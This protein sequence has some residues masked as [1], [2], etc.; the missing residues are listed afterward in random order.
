MTGRIEPMDTQSF[1]ADAADEQHFAHTLPFKIAL[2]SDYLDGDEHDP[3]RE[4]IMEV[5]MF[6]LQR[7]LA[8]C[9]TAEVSFQSAMHHD[10]IKKLEELYYDLA[11][12]NRESAYKMNMEV[13][14]NVLKIVSAGFEHDSKAARAISSIAG[15]G[16]TGNQMLQQFD[17]GAKKILE[18]EIEILRQMLQD[19]G[20]SDRHL[21]QQ[22]ERIYEIFRA[23]SQKRS[24]SIE[25][26]ARAKL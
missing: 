20:K 13:V 10:E 12:K 3:G 9:M 23:I 5:M 11:A 2:I 21:T 15:L 24:S 8:A 16:T 25:Q 18:G 19:G 17:Q 7:R 26:A 4:K 1:K 6:D 14:A 22:L